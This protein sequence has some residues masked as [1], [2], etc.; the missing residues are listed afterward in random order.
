M[1]FLPQAAEF[2]AHRDDLRRMASEIEEALQTFDNAEML[3]HMQRDLLAPHRSPRLYEDAEYSDRNDARRLLLDH[4]G[5]V[6]QKLDE[7]VEVGDFA[8]VRDHL[9]AYSQVVGDRAYFGF[10]GE[11]L[12][13]IEA[14]A[15]TY[16]VVLHVGD[17][18]YS[19][20]VTVREDPLLSDIGF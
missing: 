14:A 5:H 11:E 20:R 9:L 19:G 4:L 7:A 1:E 3:F 17:E 6:R 15:G 13:P 12:T 8:R 18:S 10:F 16:R 2:E